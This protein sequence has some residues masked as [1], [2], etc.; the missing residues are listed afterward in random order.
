M[1]LGGANSQL[2]RQLRP[3]HN[4]LRVEPCRPSQILKTTEAIFLHRK[5]ERAETR[6][7]IAK[8]IYDLYGTDNLTLLPLTPWTTKQKIG[9][10]LVVVS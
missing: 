2:T 1:R 9:L 6:T 3:L 5:L 7:S 8:D 10:F 4:G